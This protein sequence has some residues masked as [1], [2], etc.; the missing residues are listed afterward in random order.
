MVYIFHFLM[1]S[2]YHL[3]STLLVANTKGRPSMELYEV[4]IL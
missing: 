3:S 2:N 1:F 4:V